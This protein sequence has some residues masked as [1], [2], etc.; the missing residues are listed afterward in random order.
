MNKKILTIVIAVIAIIVISIAVYFIQ[1]RENETIVN[2]GKE[3][4]DFNNGEEMNDLVQCLAD[5]DVTIYGTKT[6]PACASF[7]GSFGGYDAVGPIYVD[8]NEERER[9]G[10][11][12]KT[13]Y[14]PEVQIKG[15]LY[16]GLRSPEGIAEEVGCKK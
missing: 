14:I 1:N 7:I 15:E 4:N 5:A 2:N 11:E 13:N 10:E 6:C 12:M 16:K 8:C 9:C 3:T